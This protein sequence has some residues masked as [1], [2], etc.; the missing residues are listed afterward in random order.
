[1]DE[2]KLGRDSFG[3]GS[4]L[5]PKIRPCPLAFANPF[6]PVRE[7]FNGRALGGR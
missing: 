6:A 1:M 2:V 5:A 7:L 3:I 4:L